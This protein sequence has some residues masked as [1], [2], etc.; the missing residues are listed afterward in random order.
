MSLLPTNLSGRVVPQLPNLISR[1]QP[2]ARGRHTPAGRA[3]MAS[4]G[5]VA[6]LLAALVVETVACFTMLA[7]LVHAQVPGPRA[8]LPAR[9]RAAVFRSHGGGRPP[10]WHGLSG[11]ADAVC[12]GQREL[13]VLKAAAGAVGA[14]VHPP[15]DA[16][17]GQQQTPGGRQ[18]NPTPG[19]APDVNISSRRLASW[20]A[21]ART[22]LLP[23]R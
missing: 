19:P 4:D 21:V 18:G 8:L 7:K 10:P 15:A 14:S 1:G 6:A 12:P 13:R 11:P 20:A 5:A 23:C 2:G 16:P 3:R 22:S 17:G 9:A